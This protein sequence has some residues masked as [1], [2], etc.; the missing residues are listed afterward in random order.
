MAAAACFI[1]VMD[2]DALLR[3]FLD[4]LPLPIVAVDREGIV[5]LWNPS[6]ERVYGWTT[7]EAI[8]TPHPATP[9][10][11]QA[12][13]RELRRAVFAGQVFERF[14]TVRVTRDGSRF[15]AVLTVAAV[16]AATGSVIAAVSVLH[17]VSGMQQAQE[18]LAESSEHL[19]MMLDQ[20][21]ALISTLD[22]DLRFTATRGAPMNDIGTNLVGKT[23]PEIGAAE[24]SPPMNAGRAAL[25]G[26]STRYEWRYSGRIFENLAEP[27]RNRHGEIVG[28]VNLGIDVSEQRRAA[29]ELEA[30]RQ[31]LRNL[32]AA[33]HEIEEQQRRRIAREVHDELGQPLTALR[34]ELGLL[35]NELGQRTSTAQAARI[36]T[37]FDLID[38]TLAKVREVAMQLRPAVLDDFGFRAAI[39]HELRTLEQ[40]SGI[41]TSLEMKPPSLELPPDR[42]AALFRIVQEALTNVARHANARNVSVIVEQLDDVIRLEVSD[43]GIG[44]NVRDVNATSALGLLGIRERAYAIGGEAVFESAEGRGTSVIVSIPDEDRHR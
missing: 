9:P 43:D 2:V 27:L 23:L 18:Q 21:P 8:G 32:S 25:R 37:M 39:E 31:R 13:A 7:A 14:E 16:L 4:A 5:V 26:E 20:L 35:K 41:A 12:E 22:R 1:A 15:D 30:S 40:R 19:R 28:V 36:A 24:G 42:A 11:R 6:A 10:D 33:M 29:A 34:L 3:K 17:D 38:E 44:M